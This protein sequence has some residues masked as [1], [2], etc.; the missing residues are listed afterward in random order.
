MAPT[1]ELAK[2][3]HTE[4]ACIA[5]AHGLV[6]ACLYGGAPFGPQCDELRAGLD[7]VVATPGRLLDHIRRE[8]ISLQSVRFVILDEADEMLSMGFQDDVEDILSHV[9]SSSQKL[10]FSAT[11]PK[12]VKALVSKHLDAGHAVVDVVGEGAENQAN[13]NITHECISCAPFE[14]GETLAD[15]CKVHAGAFGKTLVF[16]D[17]K[18]E[19]D[20]LAQNAKLVAMGAGVLHGD[21]PQNAREVTMENFR[22]GKIKLLIAT[23]VAARGLDVPNVDLVVQTHPPQDL[24]T[25]VHRSGRTARGGRTGTC[26]TFYSRNEEYMLRLLQHKKGIPIRRRGPAQ[27]SEIVAQAARDAVRQVDH[28]HQDNVEAFTKVAEELLA[29]RESPVFLLAA[30]LAAM[31]GYTERIKFRSLLTSYEGA[32]AM[33]LDSEREIE[34]PSKAWYLLRQMVPHEVS[35][36]CKGMQVV[37]GRRA[38]IFDCPQEHVPKV[39]NAQCWRGIKFSVATELPELEPHPNHQGNSVEDDMRQHADSQKR[40]WEKIKG[41]RSREAAEKQERRERF[42][43]GDGKGKGRGKGKGKGGADGGAKGKGKGRGRGY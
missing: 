31:T 10:L 35:E 39:L 14:R 5:S 12:W 28:I 40:R 37:K 17:T 15:L 6:A 20:E 41:Y 27:P 23:D 32:Q 19:C 9:P 3:I 13:K 34:Q 7:V 2:Q 25:Y 36:A 38:A 29:E 24:D 30:S 16:T 33:L 4:F 43:D 8:T 1:R 11:M 22:T 42:G 21:I 26:V 18:K